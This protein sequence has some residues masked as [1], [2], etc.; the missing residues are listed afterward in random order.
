MEDDALNQ[1][2]NEVISA[3]NLG[4]QAGVQNLA[5]DQISNNSIL[6]NSFSIDRN[7]P[8]SRLDQLQDDRMHATIP[9]LILTDIE[10]IDDPA[11]LAGADGGNG[12]NSSAELDRIRD[13]I[14]ELD[15]EIENDRVLI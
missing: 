15:D 12:H 10:P 3:P 13:Q 1:D 9:P 8:N 2:I 6:D 7:Q 5:A 4:R 11:N 14:Q